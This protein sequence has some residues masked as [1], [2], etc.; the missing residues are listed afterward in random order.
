MVCLTIWLVATEALI[1]DQIK[2][3]VRIELLE[4]ATRAIRGQQMLVP[5]Q[6]PSNLSGDAQMEKL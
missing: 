1:F 6:R 4:Q 5:T 2:F 3:N